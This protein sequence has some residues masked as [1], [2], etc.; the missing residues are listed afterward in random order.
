MKRSEKQ[1]LKEMNLEALH[2]KLMERKLQAVKAKQEKA[3]EKVKDKKAY[4][5]TRKE[6]ATVLTI[7]KEKELAGRKQ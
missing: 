2:T 4:R 5:K 7:I 6:I 1:K 3:S